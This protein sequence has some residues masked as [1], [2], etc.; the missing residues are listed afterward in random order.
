MKVAITRV[1]N[2]ELIIEDTI[3]HVLKT[4]DKIVALDD[5][6]T[7]NTREIL[8]TFHEVDILTGTGKWE[9]DP[10]VRQALEGHHRQAPYLH[11]VKYYKP[12][13][14][15]CFDADEF[16]T[17][18][19]VQWDNPSIGGY[20]LRLFDYYITESDREL[21]YTS[22]TKLGPEYR[23]IPMLFRPNSR[24]RF[25]TRVPG[26]IQNLAQE[27]G[28]YVKHYG[29]AISEQQWEDTCDYYI[30]YLWE[31]IPGGTTIADKWR[32]RKGKAIH[33]ESDFGRPFIEW[34]DRTN[35]DLIIDL[36]KQA[37]Q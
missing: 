37:K 36:Q 29:K 12:D 14:I 5:Y 1:R 35:L 25:N 7:D 20:K 4:F 11:A 28:G 17:F 13:W 33:T 9:T 16:A 18:E 24:L 32:A 15:Y 8:K 10:V 3:K 6:S 21:S 23:D 34:Q 22:R 2:E 26:G 30:N 27:I 31:P 19:N